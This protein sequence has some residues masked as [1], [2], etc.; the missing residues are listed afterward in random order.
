MCPCHDNLHS[1]EWVGD[2]QNTFYFQDQLSAVEEESNAIA[3]SEVEA[4]K[5]TITDKDRQI[6]ELSGELQALQAQLQTVGKYPSE[7]EEEVHKLMVET[8]ELRAKL[9]EVEGEK[10]ERERQLEAIHQKMELLQ[11]LIAELKERKHAS[12][13]VCMKFAFPLY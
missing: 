2:S 1:R 6:A 4:L 9:V 7:E 13:Q 3:G 12:S 10:Q 5:Q 11:K 8:S